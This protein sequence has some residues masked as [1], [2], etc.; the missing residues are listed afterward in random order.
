[1]R[2]DI[3][4]GKRH[5]FKAVFTKLLFKFAIYGF[6]V[7]PAKKYVSGLKVCREGVKGG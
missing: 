6:Y 2:R 1:M 7:K 3:L 5:T 4:F